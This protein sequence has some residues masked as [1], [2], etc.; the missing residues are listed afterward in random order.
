[1]D[2]SHAADE[3]LQKLLEKRGQDLVRGLIDEFRTLNR[4]VV[5]L[6]RELA[7]LADY[8]AARDRLLAIE[9]AAARILRLPRVV[10]IEADQNLRFQDGFYALEHTS[11]G[12]PFRWTGPS[13]QF[14]F[15]VFVDRTNVVQLKLE[16]LSCID[17]EIQKNISLL[18]DGDSIP[19]TVERTEFGFEATATLPPRDGHDATGLV[20]LLP[21]A[22]V[23]PGS[24]DTRALGLAFRRF[25]A[26]AV[27]AGGHDAGARGGG[28]PNADAGEIDEFDLGTSAAAE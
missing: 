19:V 21:S 20:F 11:D 13:P 17:F 1:M 26:V 18:A 2:E 15:D 6:K 25:S 27:G 4:D 12:T 16:A 28:S 24:E 3:R 14:S 5:S 9:T 22:L 23:P 10:S 7:A 8:H